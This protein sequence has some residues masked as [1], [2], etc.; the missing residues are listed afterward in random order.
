MVAK[1]RDKK[2]GGKVAIVI[3]EAEIKR[4]MHRRN[5][6]GRHQRCSGQFRF[7]ASHLDEFPYGM[8]RL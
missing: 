1:D 2:S 4:S 5:G 7:P 3:R 6:R 8:F